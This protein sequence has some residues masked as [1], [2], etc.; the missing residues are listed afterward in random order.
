M[1]WI[2]E[3]VEDKVQASL[4]MDQ[5]TCLNIEGLNCKT[6]VA[7]EFLDSLCRYDL[8]ENGLDKLI[9]TGFSH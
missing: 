4:G 9:L 5:L 8:P 3:E 6:M 1:P 7:N 2:Y